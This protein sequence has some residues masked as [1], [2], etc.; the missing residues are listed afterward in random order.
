MPDRSMF[1]YTLQF[2]S[3][4]GC[5]INF[6]LL[7][8]EAKIRLFGSLV[9]WLSSALRDCDDCLVAGALLFTLCCISD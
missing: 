9:L 6:T 3:S 8:Q 2:N 5:C 7:L 4:L 1:S